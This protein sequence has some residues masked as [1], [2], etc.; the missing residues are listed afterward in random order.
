[1]RRIQ[2]MPRI[3]V[4]AALAVAAPAAAQQSIDQTVP[5]NRTGRVEIHNLAGSVRV[6]AWDRDQIQIRGELGR[7]TE[8][9]EVSGDRNRTVIRVILPRNARNVQGSDLVVQVPAQKDVGVQTTSADVA[10]ENSTGTVQGQS[11][12][13]DVT[14]TGNPASVTGRSTSGDVRVT[15][16]SSARVNASST[17]GDVVVRGNIRESVS[18]ESVSGDV[19]VSGAT[20]EV[21]AKTVSGDVVLRGVTGRVSAGT[22]SGDAHVRDSRI[23]F[24][25]FETVSGNFTFDGELPARAA[26]NIQSHSGTVEMRIPSNTSAEFDVRTFSGDIRN[27]LGP[28]AERTSRYGPGR[29]LRFTAGSGG[30][31]VSLKT[32]SGNVRILRR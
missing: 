14:I 32:F 28:D 24:G 3:L 31:L 19:D 9:L 13:G 23:Q 17:S 10:I 7:G 11:T 5:T 16:G 12:S 2:T 22:V 4:L 26:F 20:P 8:R 6:V 29:E 30:G 27:E 1:M 21:R 15:V 18:V 25:A